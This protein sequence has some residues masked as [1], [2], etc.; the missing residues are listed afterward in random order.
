MTNVGRKL[1][2]KI[3]KV[4]A[5]HI[6]T[7][8]SKDIQNKINTLLSV[9]KK[10]PENPSIE[11]DAGHTKDLAELEKFKKDNPMLYKKPPV[12]FK[13]D[14]T[15]P[16]KSI[17]EIPINDDPGRTRKRKPKGSSEADTWEYKLSIS[18]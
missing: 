9:G 2:Y 8:D 16:K 17:D 13:Y 14:S 6:D 11:T 15:G 7:L 1:E 10:V 4:H 5:P 18:C 3:D 12:T